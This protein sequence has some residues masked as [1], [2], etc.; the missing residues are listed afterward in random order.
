MTPGKLCHVAAWHEMHGKKM[1][2]WMETRIVQKHQKWRTT[3]Q[4]EAMAQI[5][6][7]PIDSGW[8]KAGPPHKEKVQI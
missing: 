2:P 6:A 1:A 3:F 8:K 4:R 7:K 5:A